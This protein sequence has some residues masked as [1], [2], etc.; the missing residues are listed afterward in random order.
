MDVLQKYHINPISFVVGILSFSLIF[1]LT[2]TYLTKDLV[3]NER[4]GTSVYVWSTLIGL[5]L[6]GISGYFY[7][8]FYPGKKELL[9]GDF[10][11][12]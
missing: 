5:T 4:P 12:I 10:F 11:K 7:N 8:K 6:G 1:Y 9:R 2:Y 3:K